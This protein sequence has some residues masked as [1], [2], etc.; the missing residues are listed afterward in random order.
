MKTGVFA[1][2]ATCV[3]IMAGPAR[4]QSVSAELLGDVETW[5]TDAGSR[6]LARNDG[7]LNAVGRVHGFGLLRPASIVELRLIGELE[8]TTAADEEAELELEMITLRISPTRAFNIEGGK[9]LM[10]VGGFGIRRF[11]NVNPLIGAPDLYPT[12]YPWGA[13]ATGGI[14]QFDYAVG[15][16]SLPV[17]NPRYS[18]EPGERLRPVIRLG[19][20]PSP[21]FRIGAAATHGPYLGPD[22][23]SQLPAN[24]AWQDYQQTVLSADMHFSIGY[25]DA[26]A[27]VAW[28][29]YEVPTISDPVRGLGSYAE[30]KVA[31]T[32]RIFTAAR[33]ERF[34]YAFIRGI[35]T[36]TWIGVPTTQWNAEAGVGYRLSRSALVKASYRRDY[37]PGEVR[38]GSSPAPDGYA[39]AL[40]FSMLVD[41]GEMLAR[42]Y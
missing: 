19:F 36:T 32:P 9:I 17:V 8:A 25:V 13:V 18:P 34:R 35:N 37:W 21:A 4:A 30:V 22:S 28:S 39:L 16:V 6:L 2:A 29:S 15:A 33:V 11:S 20:T 5:K 7:R 14:G 31:H 27:E 24:A 40:Q 38:P 1:L 42:R 23:K 41:F 3:V 26:R 10:P 12:Q